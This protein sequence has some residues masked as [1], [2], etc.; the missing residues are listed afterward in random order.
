MMFKHKRTEYQILADEFQY[1]LYKRVKTD[2]QVIGYYNDIFNLLIKLV[3]IGCI[4][5]N[6]ASDIESMLKESLTLLKKSVLSSIE[7]P[8]SNDQVLSSTNPQGKNN[9]DI[10]EVANRL[11]KKYASALKNLGDK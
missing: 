4:G 2:W 8:T 10:T 6:K 11:K 1:T 3:R 5:N 9:H 7:V